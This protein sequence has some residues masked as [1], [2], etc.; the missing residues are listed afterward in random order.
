MNPVFVETG[1][2]IGNGIQEA[3]DAGFTEVYSIELSGKFFNICKERFK[4]KL[5]FDKVLTFDN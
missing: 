3:I 2:H 1:S 4:N 5:D